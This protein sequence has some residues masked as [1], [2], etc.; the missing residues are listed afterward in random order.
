MI[1]FISLLNNLRNNQIT[2]YDIEL[3]NKYYQPNFKPKAD[4][5]YITLTTHNYKALELNKTFLQ[6]LKS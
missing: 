1:S 5:N 3:L 6:E 2:E 4:E